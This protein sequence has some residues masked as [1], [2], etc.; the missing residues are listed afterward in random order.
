MPVFTAVQWSPESVERKTPPWVPTIQVPTYRVV[1]VRGSIARQMASHFSIP[2]F[3]AVHVAPRLTE[4]Y[5]PRSR[6]AYRVVGVSGSTASERT[7]IN[8]RPLFI[9]TH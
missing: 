2:A 4:R 8:E 5:T 6:P 1:G 7:S 9:A 3:A